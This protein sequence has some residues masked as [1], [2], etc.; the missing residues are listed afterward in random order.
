MKYLLSSVARAPEGQGQGGF[1]TGNAP[2]DEGES[3]DALKA[4]LAFDP[5]SFFVPKATEGSGEEGDGS[6][7]DTHAAGE[8]GGEP[9][10][11]AEGGKPPASGA[12]PSPEPGKKEGDDLEALRASVADF[13]KKPAAAPA[14]TKPVSEQPPRPQETKEGGDKGE[15]KGYDFNL[16]S[17]V[18]E[19]LGAEEPATRHQALNTIVN[20]LAN[21]LAGDFGKA[22]AAM[23]QHV[24]AEAVKQ[25]L[26][27]VKTQSSEDTVRSDFYNNAPDLKKLVDVMPAMDGAIWTTINAAAK[28]TNVDSWTPE[29]RDKAAN[30]IR[31]QLGLPAP[32]AGQG[33]PQNPPPNGGGKPPRKPSFNA[34]GGGPSGRPANGGDTNE[35]AAVVNAGQ[36]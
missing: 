19:A 30:L 24:Q 28:A 31:L 13:L 12:Q 27:Q 10:A 1:E 36:T 5:S 7:K 33:A 15:F 34:G 14:E 29:F 20:G 2:P 18:V 26:A 32:A 4:A 23:A 8:G 3:Q 11:G 6:P 21:R 9:G 35:F 17:N 16:P 22:M 25:A